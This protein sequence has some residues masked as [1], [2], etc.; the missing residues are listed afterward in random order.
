MMQKQPDLVAKAQEMM[1]KY[2]VI[3]DV[4]WCVS[5]CVLYCMLCIILYAVYHIV[6][7]VSLYPVCMLLHTLCAFPCICIAFC[8]VCMLLCA[9]SYTPCPPALQL[10]TKC[11]TT[12]L[13]LLY[14]YLPIPACL[15]KSSSAW[16]PWHQAW[17][18]Q[19]HPPCQ[20]HPQVRASKYNGNH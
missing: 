16:L 18:C 2:V 15:L 1:A 3:D 5:Y 20:V 9:C 19:V 12:A 14:L 4:D 13:Q 8:P 11:S 10:L 7:C 6:C 17:A